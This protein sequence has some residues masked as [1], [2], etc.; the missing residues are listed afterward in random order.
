MKAGEEHFQDVKYYV[1]KGFPNNTDVQNEFGFDDYAKARGNVA[2]F[3]LFLKNVGLKLNDTK[4]K[5]TLRTKGMPATMLTI[6]AAL[7][8]AEKPPTGITTTPKKAAPAPP[9]TEE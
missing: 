1:G 5:E 4:Y 6:S 2:K 8:G 7:A 3:I 9:R